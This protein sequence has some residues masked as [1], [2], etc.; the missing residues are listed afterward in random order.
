VPLRQRE[1]IQKL[2]RPRRVNLRAQSHQIVIPSEVEE[3][4]I[5]SFRW[6]AK[7]ASE[8]FRSAQHNNGRIEIAKRLGVLFLQII[9]RDLEGV[10]VG[11][12]EIDRVR[13]FVILKFKFDS[14]LF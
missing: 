6:R 1:K 8:M 13:N 10:T 5:I 2:L 9:G 14:A 11:I 3:S 7:Q 4:L 12:A